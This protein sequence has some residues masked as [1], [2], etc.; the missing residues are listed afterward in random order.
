MTVYSI[1]DCLMHTMSENHEKAQIIML[2]HKNTVETPYPLSVWA[3]Q[4]IT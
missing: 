2:K 4:H 3:L 1:I